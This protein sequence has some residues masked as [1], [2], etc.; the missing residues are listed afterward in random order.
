MKFYTLVLE[1]YSKQNFVTH[2]YQGWLRT[3]VKLSEGHII[4]ESTCE[5]SHLLLNN[6]NHLDKS[7]HF[8]RENKNIHRYF[9]S[10]LMPKNIIVCMQNYVLSNKYTQLRTTLV[11]AYTFLLSSFLHMKKVLYSWK[12]S[13]NSIFDGFTCVWDVLNTISPF[14]ECLSI[15]MSSKF[16]GHCISRT[17]SQKLMK[18]YIQLHLDTIWCWLHSGPYRS[19]SSDVVRNF[20]F[21]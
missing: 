2:K 20:W 12:F 18:L 1:L 21:L 13:I 17:N 14:L 15:C 6:F 4:S 5:V 19:R 11:Y 16:C 7:F 9:I 10:Y 8:S 3:S